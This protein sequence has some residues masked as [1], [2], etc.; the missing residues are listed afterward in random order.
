MIGGFLM[1]RLLM[2]RLGQHEQRSVGRRRID[3]QRNPEHRAQLL[4]DQNVGGRAVR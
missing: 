2:G 3:P 1:G 4:V